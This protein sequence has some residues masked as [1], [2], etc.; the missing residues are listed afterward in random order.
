[1]GVVPVECLFSL[2][3][4]AGEQSPEILSVLLCLRDWVGDSGKRQ[5]GREN[6][7]AMHGFV[8]GATRFDFQVLVCES[9]L[10][11][12]SGPSDNHGNTHATIVAA[13]LAALGREVVK[14]ALIFHLLK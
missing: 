14:I 12:L 6:V 10:W 3:V 5:D 11:V 7:V 9:I 4:S 13:S 2:K 8:A 1:M